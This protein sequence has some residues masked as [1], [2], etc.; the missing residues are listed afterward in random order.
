M[1]LL[2]VFFLFSKVREA[3]SMLFSGVQTPKNSVWF[4]VV[5]FCSMNGRKASNVLVYWKNN[6]TV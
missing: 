5:S 2:N 3:Q 4:M 6:V 1:C